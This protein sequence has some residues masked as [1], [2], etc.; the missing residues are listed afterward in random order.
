MG[1][2]GWERIC[3]CFSIAGAESH[4]VT[5]QINIE[6][7]NTFEI[8]NLAILYTTPN[9]LVFSNKRLDVHFM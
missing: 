6:K 7:K 3:D 5:K 1:D 9:L 8:A 4:P 2:C